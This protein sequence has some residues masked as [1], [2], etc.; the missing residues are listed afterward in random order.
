MDSPPLLSKNALI[1]LAMIKINPDGT[2]KDTCT[3]ELRIKS[4]KPPDD[5]D[6]LL[7]EYNDKFQG[8]GCF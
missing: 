6:A 4:V 8:I 1:E 5:I 7:S 2:L 3:D